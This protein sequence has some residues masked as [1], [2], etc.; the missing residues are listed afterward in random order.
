MRVIQSLELVLALAS[1]ELSQEVCL[2]VCLVECLAAREWDA[3]SLVECLVQ[4]KVKGIQMR[5]LRLR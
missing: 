4:L 2:E 3:D 1:L 5:I